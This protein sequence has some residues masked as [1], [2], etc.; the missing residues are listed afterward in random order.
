[1]ERLSREG[2]EDF[3]PNKQCMHKQIET[4][5]IRE[6]KIR[7]KIQLNVGIKRKYKMKQKRFV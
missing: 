3:Q 7:S 6:V 5:L 1:M 2:K 4:V